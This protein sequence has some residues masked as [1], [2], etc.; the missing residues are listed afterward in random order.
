MRETGEVFRGMK[1][2]LVKLF[3]AFRNAVVP[4]P[5]KSK[6]AS[7]ARRAAPEKPYLNSGIHQTDEAP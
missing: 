3:P 2:I 6:S 5:S 1:P 7:D 4:R